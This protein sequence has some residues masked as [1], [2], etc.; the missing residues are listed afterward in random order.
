[1]L[2][3]ILFQI[4]LK[5]EIEQNSTVTE[6]DE[7]LKLSIMDMLDECEFNLRS[8]KDITLGVTISNGNGQ[9]N[10]ITQERADIATLLSHAYKLI[11]DHR[12]N[13]KNLMEMEALKISGEG[14]IKNTLS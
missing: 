8:F 4:P 11:V 6:V 10:Q 9:R 13:Q 3:D 14:I 2:E 5:I 1:M 12:N 7:R